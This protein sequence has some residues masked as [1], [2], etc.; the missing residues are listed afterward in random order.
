MYGERVTIASKKTMYDI[1]RKE[2]KDYEIKCKLSKPEFSSIIR[3]L[4]NS[5]SVKNKIKRMINAI[6]I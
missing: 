1:Y 4:K 2:G 3:C 5:K 6:D